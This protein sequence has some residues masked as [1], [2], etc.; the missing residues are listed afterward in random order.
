MQHAA[1][2]GGRQKDRPLAIVTLHES[3][4][5]PVAFDTAL[6]LSEQVW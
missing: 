1:H 5:V 4:S 6:D 2:L 3:V